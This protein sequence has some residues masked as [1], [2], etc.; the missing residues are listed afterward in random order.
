[1]IWLIFVVLEI[2]RNYILIEVLKLRPHYGYS[3][4]IR[5]G[6]AAIFLFWRHPEFD[7]L[8]DVT[9]IFPSTVYALFQW[10]SFYILFD[11]ILNLLRGKP[12]FYQGEHSGYTDG[13]SS[14]KYLMLKAASLVILILS[15]IVMY[16]K[17]Y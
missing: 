9:T 2:T 6:F 7:P 1:M 14:P 3:A 15:T 13:L 11:P 8:G 12:V 5:F 4:I 16:A 17:D 10:S